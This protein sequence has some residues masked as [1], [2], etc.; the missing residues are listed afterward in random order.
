MGLTL[1]GGTV[2]VSLDPPRLVHGDVVVDG[3]RVVAVGAAGGTAAG[4]A[5]DC[6]GCLI[7]PGQV[8]AHTH[9]YSA[10]ARGMPYRLP[11]PRNFLQILQRV[12][13]RLDRALDEA[14]LRASALLGGLEALLAGTTTLID[15]H[16]SPNAI[17]GALDVIAEALETLGVR[18]V[19]C[20]EVTD[21]DGP[22]RARAGLAENRRFLRRRHPLTRGLA[23]AHASFTL[24]EETLAECVAVARAAG[25]GVHIHVAEDLAD[26]RDALARFERRVVRRLADAGALDGGA[27]LAHCVHVDEEEVAL[28]QAHRATV[29]HNARSN[30]HN[31]VGR[32]PVGRLGGRVV[33]GTDGIGGDMFAEGR[34]AYWRARE[35]DIAVGVDWPLRRL[36]AAAALA[37]RLFGEPLLGRL[38]PGAPADL[39]VLAYLP[40][41]P[42]AAENVAGHWVFGLSAAQVRDVVVAGE[43]VVADRQPTR[44]D[45]AAVVAEATAQAARLWQRLEALGPHPYEPAGT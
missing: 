27:L 32:A 31:S 41:T 26:Q 38:E 35:D 28:I 43:L 22:E 29:A 19:L 1:R 16:A 33:L 21:R 36:A 15:H 25:V 12:W 5:R 13:W 3:G 39:V 6:S 10:L 4:P 20:Y 30:M 23:G 18:S 7:L 17:D 24:S 40:P 44:V 37:G 11:P 42:L 8:N 45:R 9:L 34:A 14:S 2:L